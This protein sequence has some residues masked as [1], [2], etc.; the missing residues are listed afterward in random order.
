MI[1]AAAAAAAP[2][3]WAN[4]V[5]PRLGLGLRGRTVANVGYAVGYRAL[6]DGQ[7]N[8][9]SANGLRLGLAGAGAVVAGF[10]AALSVPA[11]RAALASSSSREPEVAAHEWISLHI[12]AGTVF[13]E[14]TVFRGTLDPLL[15]ANL[16]RGPALLV[17]ALTFGLCHITPARAV[18]DPVLPTVVA[19]TAAGLAFTLLARRAESATAP[20]LVHLA[21]NAGGALL[22][23][24]STRGASDRNRPVAANMA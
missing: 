10:G 18:G 9:L 21:L 17:G 2:V 3:V 14:E 20:A 15:S 1:R 12:P 11:V 19:T 8:W 4:V 24:R 22:T 5:L 13:A 6:F 23:L 16:G 7:P